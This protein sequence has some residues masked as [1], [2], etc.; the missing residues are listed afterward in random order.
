MASEAALVD[1]VSTLLDSEYSA[2]A[3]FAFVLYD[4]LI[5]LDKE[6]QYFWDYRK[7]RK[8]TAAAL[9]YGL[10][11]YPA[12]FGEIFQLQTAFPLSDTTAANIPYA[13]APAMFS[14][15]RIYALSPNNMAISI[16]TFLLLFMP[17]FVNT[18]INAMDKAA[19]QPS[20]FNCSVV[21]TP[22]TP[23]VASRVI[24]A[25]NVLNMLF[26]PIASPIGITLGS[27]ANITNN[28]V[29]AV[30]TCHFLF[31]LREAHRSAAP[32][33]SPSA[34][35]SLYL[36]EGSPEEGSPGALPAF[37]ASMGSQL[38]SPG[39]HLRIQ[40]SDRRGESSFAYWFL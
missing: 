35:P 2:F 15:I 30:L 31:D 40:R 6:I 25:M 21:K 27:I 24:T 14:A 16:S 8:L 13:I 20:P 36:A 18:I 1:A 28:P 34:V 4:W 37:I 38:H 9:L 11:R 19:R 26:I 3:M 33:S 22:V 10:S 12:I 5:N 39:L 32:P 7:G 29:T 23:E 17:T